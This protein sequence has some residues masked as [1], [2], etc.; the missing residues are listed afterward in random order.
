MKLFLSTILMF[1]GLT[2]LS[3]AQDVQFISINEIKPDS[4]DAFEGYQETIRPIMDTYSGRYVSTDLIA[5]LAGEASDQTVVNFGSMGPMANAQAFFQDADFQAAFP[6]LMMALDGHYSYTPGGPLPAFDEFES[7]S[8]ILFVASNDSA[9][10]DAITAHLGD[11]SL[12]ARMPAVQAIS[13]IGPT[14]NQEAPPSE[15]VIWSISD[16]D[17][18]SSDALSG[19]EIALVLQVR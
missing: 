2:G 4:V 18:V 16:E 5:T 15:L 8:C 7:G 9:Q 12:M 6:T 1:I 13:G 17:D 10:V 19:A 14:A 3:Q 11:D